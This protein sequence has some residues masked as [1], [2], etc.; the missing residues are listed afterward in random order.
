MTHPNPKGVLLTA[1]YLKD[2]PEYRQEV[3]KIYRDEEE[4]N[5]MGVHGVNHQPMCISQSILWENG[6]LA[7]GVNGD[8]EYKYPFAKVKYAH[9]KITRKKYQEMRDKYLLDEEKLVL[10]AWGQVSSRSGAQQRRMD[11]ARRSHSNAVRRG[12]KVATYL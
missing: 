8:T 1:R 4:V 7:M 12:K 2:N 11:K 10:N 3:I 6:H 5:G 9:P